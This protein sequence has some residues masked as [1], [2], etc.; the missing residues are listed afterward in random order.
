MGDYYNLKGVKIGSDGNLDDKKYLIHDK[1]EA[2]CIETSST[3][4][5]TKDLK[6]GS[7]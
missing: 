5:S 1:K 4:I 3:N 6:E 2:K 7:F